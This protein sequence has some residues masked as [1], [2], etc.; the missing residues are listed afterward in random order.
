MSEYRELYS[1]RNRVITVLFLAGTAFIHY[2]RMND[3]QLFI[4]IACV[5]FVIALICRI[6]DTFFPEEDEDDKLESESITRLWI[7]VFLIWTI[8][9]PLIGLVIGFLYYSIYSCLF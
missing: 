5:L 6:Q 2:I 8:G 1:V 7:S 9:L 4:Y 3:L